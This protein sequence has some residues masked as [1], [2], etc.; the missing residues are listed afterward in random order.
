MNG[1]PL[2]EFNKDIGQRKSKGQG[3][4]G[5]WHAIIPAGALVP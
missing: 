1:H 5:L 3:V 4:G 2:Y